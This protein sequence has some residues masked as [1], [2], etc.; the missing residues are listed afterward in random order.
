MSDNKHTR[1]GFN[2]K[3]YYIALILCAAAIGISGYLYYQNTA[4]QEQ[5]LLLQ[6]EEPQEELQAEPRETQAL[7]AIAT[8][9]PA[10]ETTVPA[11]QPSA[12][13]TEKK[14]L[15]TAAPVS[16]ETLAGYAMDCL[17]YNE[18]TRD[19][20][21]HNGVDIAAQEGTAVLAAADGVV[22][23]VFED[24]TL[25][26]TVVIRHEG[27]YVTRYASLAETV[28][29]Q[30][31]DKVTLGQT[32]GYVGA[33]ALVETVLGPHVHFSVSFQDAPMDPA[34]FLALS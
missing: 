1:R 8:Q 27:G 17:S 11:T 7:E 5:T 13:P 10:P 33:T 19:W 3:G 2:G 6:E 29:V 32:I 4:Q 15:K 26:Y 30:A 34:E 31:G 16:G 18:T 12:A 20:R 22:A 25:G 9:P 24:D 14:P 23:E 21:V 28:A